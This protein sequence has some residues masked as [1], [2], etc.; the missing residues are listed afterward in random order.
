MPKNRK[1][2]KRDGRI[3]KMKTPS[4]FRIGNRK[5]NLSGLQ[6]SNDDLLEVLTN[7]GKKKDHH[8]A[9]T[10]LASRNYSI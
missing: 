2:V 10:I 4:K 1:I 6:M 3:F 9:K 7:V 5:S 8:K